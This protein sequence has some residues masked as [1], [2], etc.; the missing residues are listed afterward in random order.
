MI[1]MEQF[2][3]GHGSPE[4]REKVVS[5]WQHLLI[6]QVADNDFSRIV[7]QECTLVDS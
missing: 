3:A 2:S 1:R 4:F 6:A 7:R 5:G